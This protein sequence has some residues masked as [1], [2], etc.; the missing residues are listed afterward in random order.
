MTRKRV[1]PRVWVE[2]GGWNVE[3]SFRCSARVTSEK[4]QER[5]EMDESRLTAIEA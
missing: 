4:G 3:P 5:R 1:M 2:N